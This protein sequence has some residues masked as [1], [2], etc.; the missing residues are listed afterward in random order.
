MGE[1][2]GGGDQAQALRAVALAAEG[3]GEDMGNSARVREPL[4]YGRECGGIHD[5]SQA[6]P[7]PWVPGQGEQALRYSLQVRAHHQGI[8]M[9]EGRA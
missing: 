9:D 7:R 1:G 2:S 6:F 3:A 8:G 5:G 4:G